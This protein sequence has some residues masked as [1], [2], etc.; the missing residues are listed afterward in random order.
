MCTLSW[1]ATEEGLTICFN[2]DESITRPVAEAPRLHKVGKNSFLAP[3]DPVGGGTWLA[4]R[5][6]GTALA[7]LNH[8]GG[9]PPITP[10]HSRGL[11]VWQLAAA[12]DLSTTWREIA[13][14]LDGISPFHL[15]TLRRNAVRAYTWDGLDLSTLRASWPT[16]MFTASSSNVPS[17]LLPRKRAFAEMAR[18]NKLLTT[19]DLTRFHEGADHLDPHSSVWMDRG[20]RR[21]VSQSRIE[22]GDTMA[23]FSYRECSGRQ[24]PPGNWCHCEI[25]VP[26]P[27]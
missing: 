22:I 19:A 13:R 17:V 18:R 1:L 10:K 2:R 27:R 5:T 7:L 11:V 16:G 21:T 12:A 9:H 15:I 26:P 8:Y 20:E 24:H 25:L 23:R 3:R 14:S 6:D 4:L